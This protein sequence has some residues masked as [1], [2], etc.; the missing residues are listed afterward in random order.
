MNTPR[1]QTCAMCVTLDADGTAHL[2]H[3]PGVGACPGSGLPPAEGSTME[4]VKRAE[5]L[6]GELMPRTRGVT[7]TTFAEPTRPQGGGPLAGVF[8]D[9][10]RIFGSGS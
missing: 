1:C 3:A 9:F 7:L 5:P 10:G 8:A 4:P 2:H 6:E